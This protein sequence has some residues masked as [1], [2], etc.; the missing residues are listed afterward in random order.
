M[1]SVAYELLVAASVEL[2]EET[3]FHVRA[4]VLQALETAAQREDEA[5]K[6]HI[7]LLLQNATLA[8]RDQMP[9]SQD[10]G[11]PL[12]LVTVGEEVQLEGGTIRGAIEEGMRDV[13]QRHAFAVW[14]SQQPFHAEPD[15]RER[16]SPHIIL[17]TQEGD[18]LLIQCMRLGQHSERTCRIFSMDM[19]LD[20]AALKEAVIE[21]V[22]AAAQQFAPP[23]IVGLGV[24]GSMAEVGLLAQK[25]LLRPIGKPHHELDFARIEQE[26]LAA[27]NA[28]PAGPG[29]WGGQSTALA[30]HLQT[31]RTHQETVPVCVYLQASTMRTGER[32]I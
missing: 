15:Q 7:E 11:V 5:G 21:S 24:G 18:D 1:R 22:E 14:S 3:L 26:L 10:A 17:E 9:L 12:F 8:A 23:Y 31:K 32:T 4:D 13:Q 25:A 30:V 19:P 6:T 29:G 16:I 28:L 20:H 2:C 27:L